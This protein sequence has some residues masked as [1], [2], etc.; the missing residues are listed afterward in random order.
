MKKKQILRLVQGN[1][2][3]SMFQMVKTKDTE[4]ELSFHKL[5]NSH[6]D[7]FLFEKNTEEVA[8]LED[9]IEEYSFVSL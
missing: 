8:F 6:V 3:K 4:R 5:S 1:Q 7:L 2:Y 9:F